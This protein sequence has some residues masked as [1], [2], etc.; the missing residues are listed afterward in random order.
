[1]IDPRLEYLSLK[2]DKS[3]RFTINNLCSPSKVDI[4][5][6][7]NVKYNYELTDSAK[8]SSIGNFLTKISNVKDMTICW[9]TLKVYRMYMMESNMRIW[10]MD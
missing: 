6:D 4:A 10:F 2:D 3:T 5:V 7:F 1:M 9:K 8:R